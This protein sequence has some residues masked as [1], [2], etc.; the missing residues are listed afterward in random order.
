MNDREFENRFQ[1]LQGL[2]KEPEN[3]EHFVLLY[4]IL[5]IT[6]KQGLA[7]ARTVA[8]IQECRGQGVRLKRLLLEQIAYLRNLRD[9][10]MLADDEAL[11]QAQAVEI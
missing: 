6:I 10:A 4:R 9:E 5:L 3:I 7:M 2:S 11:A 8:D 1:A